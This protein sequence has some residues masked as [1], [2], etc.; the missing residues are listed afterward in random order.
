MDALEVLGPR[1]ALRARLIA[2]RLKHGSGAARH[3]APVARDGCL[4]LA[5]PRLKQLV[6]ALANA[7]VVEGVGCGRILRAGADTPPRAAQDACE[8][9]VG[10]ASWPHVAHPIVPRLVDGIEAGGLGDGP[11]AIVVPSVNL[12]YDVLVPDATIIT[13]DEVIALAQVLVAR[14]GE[15]V[16][17]VKSLDVPCREQVQASEVLTKASEAGNSYSHLSRQSNVVVDAPVT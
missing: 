16:G 10:R 11:A 3:L 7:L 4:K 2:A 5:A 1:E 9:R 15:L 8:C 6:D 12:V 13:P 17:G 14:D